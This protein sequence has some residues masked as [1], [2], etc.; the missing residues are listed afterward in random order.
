MA[1]AGK[2]EVV[3]ATGGYVDN[4][5]LS[6]GDN[7]QVQLSIMLFDGGNFLNWSRNVRMTLGAKNKLGYIDGSCTKPE[8]ALKSLVNDLGMIIR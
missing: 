5:L 4:F 6:S 2:E 3:A 1:G 7:P 8:E